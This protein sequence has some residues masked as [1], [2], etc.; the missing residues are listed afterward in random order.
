MFT[1][2]LIGLSFAS[3]FLSFV[4]GITTLLSIVATIF[5][6]HVAIFGLIFLCLVVFGATVIADDIF[7]R[8]NKEYR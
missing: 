8:T 3:L 4:L 1:R 6:P 2:I 7:S 5:S